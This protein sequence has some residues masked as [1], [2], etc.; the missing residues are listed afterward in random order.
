[1][2]IHEIIEQLP[3]NEFQALTDRL[4]KKNISKL[5]EH[6]SQEHVFS[7]SYHSLSRRMRQFFDSVYAETRDRSFRELRE[8]RGITITDLKMFQ[9]RTLLFLLPSSTKP[10]KVAIPLEY[11][12]FNE[13]KLND[14]YSLIATL[15]TY[16]E[17]RLH[18]V[19]RSYNIKPSDTF[20]IYVANIFSHILE[21]VAKIKSDLSNEE[22][23]ILHFISLYG[24]SISIE[25]FKNKFSRQTKFSHPNQLFSIDELLGIHQLDDFTPLQKLFGKCFLIPITDFDG[26]TL[27]EI[28]I[29]TELFSTIAGDFVKTREIKRKK[30]QEQM[31]ISSTIQLIQPKSDSLNNDLKKILL[32]TENLQPRATQSALPFKTDY[33]RMLSIVK[34]NQD[35]L[36]FLFQYAKWLGILRTRNGRFETS[37]ECINYL[38][39]PIRDQHLLA[40]NFIQEYLLNDESEA[41]QNIQQIH[42]LILHIFKA[43]KRNLIS[44]SF[45]RQY[46]SIEPE[47][48]QLYEDYRPYTFA[49]EK[50]VSRI[51]QRY[52]WLGLIEANT[53]L[54][55]I[56]LSSAGFFAICGA[57]LRLESPTPYE[58]KFIVQPNNEILAFSNMRFEILLML[59]RIALIKSMDVTIRFQINKIQLVHAIQNEVTI[60]QLRE[61]LNKH[62]KTPLPQTVL[63]LLQELEKKED[64]VQLVPISA[65]LQFRDL[66]VLTQAKI[67]LKDYI[68]DVTSRNKLFLKP[69]V[70]LHQ[71]EQSLKR[72]GLFIKSLVKDSIK[73]SKGI[74]RLQDLLGKIEVPPFNLDELTFTNPASTKPD[75]K[76]LFYFAVEHGLRVK[77]EYSSNSFSNSIRQIEPHQL[78]ENILNAYCYTVEMRRTFRIDR[79]KWAELVR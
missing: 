11:F 70:D 22:Q 51:L 48:R 76:Q 58:E 23:E 68:L 61:F 77:M 7:N 42:Q 1:M 2:R 75:L 78:S 67:L 72:K 53:D 17:M 18:R 38:N 9:E 73:V 5:V 8:T 21:N 55:V 31:L 3:P 26:K 64:E 54:S 36:L 66:D 60:F 46:A 52:Y 69:E 27:K 13:V 34:L 14:S 44:P 4:A 32:L 45:F 19:A 49:F 20:S 24:N 71:I 74:N 28:A 59:A 12:F 16:R 43:Y 50:Q 33:R 25:R 63:Y 29:P 6:L 37:P 15:R 10:E 62:S 47:F 39:L 79:I 41:E 56:R 30:L 57:L 65:Y 35:Y 40:F